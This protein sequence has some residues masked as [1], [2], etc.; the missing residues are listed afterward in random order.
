MSKKKNI[1]CD[2]I[3]NKDSNLYIN[4]FGVILLLLITILKK[5]INGDWYVYAYLINYMVLG[6]DVIYTAIKRLMSGKVVPNLLISVAT[7]GALILG[8]YFQAIGVL[9]LFKLGEYLQNKAIDNSKK[10]IESVLNLKD[11]FVNV[12]VSDKIVNMKVE[13]VKIGDIIVV[14]TGGKIW[15]D[16]KIIKGNTILDMSALTG[17]SIPKSFEVGDDVLSGTINLGDVISVEVT[18][19]IT[20]STISRIIGLI[21]EATEKKSVAET[22]ISRF[23]SI[24][25]PAVSLISFSVVISPLVI[26]WSWSLALETGLQILVISTPCVLV[27][28]IPLCY[29]IGIGACG[30]KGILI[31]GSNYLDVISN[32]S[33]M[34]F[35]KTGT[36]TKGI[37]KISKVKLV[38]QNYSNDD[39]LDYIVISEYYSTHYIAKSIL[40]D[41]HKEIDTNRISFYNELAGLG[42][43]LKIDNKDV[44]VGNRKLMIQENIEVDQPEKIGTTVY[45]S[46]DGKYIGYLVL[47]DEIKDDSKKLVLELKKQGIKKIIMLTGDAKSHAEEIANILGIDDVYSELLPQDKATILEEIKSNAEGKVSFVGDGINDAPVLALS[48]VGIAMGKGSDLAIETADIILMTDEPS[49]L[50]EC[51]KISKK[52]KKIV[53]QI[54]IISITVKAVFLLLTTL[55]ITNL[56]MAL[57]AD[58]AVSLFCVLNCIRILDIKKD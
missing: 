48:D 30:K 17:E 39:V 46:I 34:V 42:I 43:K 45:L 27:L 7:L 6:Y 56:F 52:T 58:I 31:K 37:F 19:D 21:N 26:K 1:S 3:T 36:L 47:S 14:K 16:G 33:T 41:Y 49:K 4:I 5:Y 11:E 8:Q 28:S 38:N 15:L 12:L 20:N 18:S 51:I 40:S 23:S 53:I 57:F 13:D 29:F 55:G 44:V 2:G 24:Y 54:I 50:I 35:D 10:R 32:V 9:I 25:T 22:F